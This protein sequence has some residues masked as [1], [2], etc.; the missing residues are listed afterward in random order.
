MNYTFITA[1]ILSN[2]RSLRIAEER[3]IEDETIIYF[4]N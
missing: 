1:F 3:L 2:N 4:L